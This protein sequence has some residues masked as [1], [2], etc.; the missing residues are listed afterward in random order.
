MYVDAD[1]DPATVVADLEAQL[2]HWGELQASCAT[3]KEYQVLFE[4]EPEDVGSLLL[5]EKELNSR[6]Q[7]GSTLIGWHCE[8]LTRDD[9]VVGWPA[10]PEYRSKGPS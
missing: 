4:L 3:C 10:H 1:A 7:V 2:A 8:V 5:V 6:Y 9:P